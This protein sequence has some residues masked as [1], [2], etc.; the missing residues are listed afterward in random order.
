MIFRRPRIRRR[1][2]RTCSRA[3]CASGAR[4]SA[5]WATEAPARQTNPIREA[6]TAPKLM[7]DKG[8]LMMWARRWLSPEDR[9]SRGLCAKQTQSAPFGYIASESAAAGGCVWEWAMAEGGLEIRDS[10]PPCGRRA[11]Q[12]LFASFGYIG[13]V[14]GARLRVGDSGARDTGRSCGRNVKQSQF[15]GFLGQEGGWA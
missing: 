9:R 2:P 10:R 6:E 8:L 12:T 7:M 5:G 13:A 1:R 11:K 14:E 4:R 3:P 15:A